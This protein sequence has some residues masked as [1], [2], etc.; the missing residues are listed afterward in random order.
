MSCAREAALSDPKNLKLLFP[1]D[2]VSFVPETDTWLVDDEVHADM[3]E[4]LDAHIKLCDGCQAEYHE[5]WLY[6]GRGT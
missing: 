3:A 6:G 2:T 1:K 5:I 4:L